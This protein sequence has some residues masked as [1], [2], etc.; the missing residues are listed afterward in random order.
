MNTMLDHKSVLRT[1]L[2]A[3]TLMVALVLFEQ[4]G[5]YARVAPALQR[6]FTPLRST[7]VRLVQMIQLPLSAIFTAV[8][9]AERIKDLEE[10]YARAQVEIASLEMIREENNELRA[11]LDQPTVTAEDQFVTRPILSLSYPAIEGGA[12]D[13]VSEGS[14]ITRQGILLGTV[15]E[16]REHQARVHLLGSVDT[17]PI[18]A[19]TQTGAQGILAGDGHRLVVREVLKNAQVAPGDRVTTV[20]QEGIPGQLFVGTVA[21]VED[22]PEAATKTLIVE[23]PLSFYD[24]RVVEVW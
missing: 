7:N 17:D 4:V 2:Y 8:D 10:R 20:G 18:V 24:A 19:Q 12:L 16:V 9:K 13:G 11:L 5:L 6:A 15:H 23:Q 21:V 14:L 3:L 1:R 22:R